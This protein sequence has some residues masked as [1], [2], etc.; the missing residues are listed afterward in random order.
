MVL[1]FPGHKGLHSACLRIRHAEGSRAAAQSDSAHRRA[2]FC[3]LHPFTVKS[4]LDMESKFPRLHRSGQFAAQSFRQAG[5][6]IDAERPH[7]GKPKTCRQTGI[8]AAGRQIQIG[9]RTDRRNRMTGQQPRSGIRRQ[10]FQGIKNHRM[11]ADNQLCTT[12]CRLT[13]NIR[14]NIQRQEY[15]VHLFLPVSSQ[16]AR[17]VKAHRGGKWRP[18][19][20]KF[21]DI[22]Y[23]CHVAAL[24]SPASCS[25]WLQIVS[26]ASACA[27]SPVWR[28]P[29]ARFLKEAA[30]P[31]R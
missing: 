31:A 6:R 23:F 30:R 5:G 12:G 22:L 4:I 15:G 13:H 28:S 14:R 26:K 10:T 9:M 21:I 17:V 24:P 19:I 27:I 16:K 11:M 8:N 1:G 20:Q 2:S 29:F 25:I 18:F 7:I 3:K